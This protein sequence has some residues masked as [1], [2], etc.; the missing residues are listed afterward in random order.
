MFVYIY[1]HTCIQTHIHINTHTLKQPVKLKEKQ[2]I[3][4][5][6][7]KYIKKGIIN[8]QFIQK[9]EE[10]EEKENKD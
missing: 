10:N 1:T 6:K 3:K 2:R 4:S 8:I 7:P 5:N 9:K